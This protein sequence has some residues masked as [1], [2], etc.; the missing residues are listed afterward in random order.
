[1]PKTTFIYLNSIFSLTSTYATFHVLKFA[2][3]NVFLTKEWF[4]MAWVNNLDCS[5][6][7]KN[8]FKTIGRTCCCPKRNF[9]TIASS[10]KKLV[11]MS[12]RPISSFCIFGVRMERDKCSD[13]ESF[14]C[15][16]FIHFNRYIRLKKLTYS[17][18]SQ[19]YKSSKLYLIWRY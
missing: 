7:A 15:S 16:M 12:R 1:M 4:G 13:W 8:Y 11:Q 3:R 10:A 19:N 2:R 6:V 17:Q 18:W 9:G 5:C 14:I